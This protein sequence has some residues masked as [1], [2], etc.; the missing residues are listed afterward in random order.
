MDNRFNSHMT[1]LMGS[2]CVIHEVKVL[3]RNE[4]GRT[5]TYNLEHNLLRPSQ[6]L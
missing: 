6:W 4:V 5:T 2:V 1:S 3:S